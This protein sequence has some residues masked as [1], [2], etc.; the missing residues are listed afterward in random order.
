MDASEPNNVDTGPSQ[1]DLRDHP[2]EN[3]PRSA[4]DASEPS[5]HDF[6]CSPTPTPSVPDKDSP[7][8]DNPDNNELDGLAST[9][10]SSPSM[11]TAVLV[12]SAPEPPVPNLP[13]LSLTGNDPPRDEPDENEEKGYYYGL[14]SRPRLIARS[15]T[16]PWQQ[17]YILSFPRPKTLQVV[18][19][20]HPIAE[21]WC[22]GLYKEIV[23]VL[24]NVSFTTIDVVR[25]GYPQAGEDEELPPVVLWIGVQPGSLSSRVGNKI[26]EACV[27]FTLI[28]PTRSHEKLELTK[29]RRL[30]SCDSTSLSMFNVRSESRNI[31]RPHRRPHR[32]PHI[33]HLKQLP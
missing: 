26:V 30:K 22:T 28:C 15:S 7:D 8:K 23:E 13:T 12:R 27:S 25:I 5:H 2:C 32:R 4:H 10:S 19:R 1:E 31:G 16:Q 24:K 14:P 3:R 18:E 20:S 11:A 29:I 9:L 33:W 21:V 6:F 17:S